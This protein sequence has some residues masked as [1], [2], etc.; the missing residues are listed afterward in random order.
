MA[1]CPL[2]HG[3]DPNETVTAIISLLDLTVNNQPQR[4]K[5]VESAYKDNNFIETLLMKAKT[6]DKGIK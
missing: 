2:L 6:T 3:V 5:K 4:M 1:E